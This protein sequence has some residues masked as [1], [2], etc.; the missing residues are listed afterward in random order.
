MSLAPTR[1]LPLARFG[2]RT[3]AETCAACGMTG[4]LAN[5]AGVV[6]YL[7]GDYGVYPRRAPIFLHA[8]VKSHYKAPCSTL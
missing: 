1:S 6:S 5:L 8:L 7:Y 4:A 3:V 2:T